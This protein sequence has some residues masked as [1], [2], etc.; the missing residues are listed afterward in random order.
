MK[1]HSEEDRKV[2]ETLG[3]VLASSDR[4]LVITSGAD[5]ARRSKNGGPAL[6]IDP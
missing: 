2:I 6:E 4:P 1:Q 3:E 5:L